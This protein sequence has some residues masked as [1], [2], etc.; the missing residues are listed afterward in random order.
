MS[1]TPVAIIDKELNNIDKIS[2]L[3]EKFSDVDIMRTSSSLDDLEMLLGKKVP[4]LVWIGPTYSLEDIEDQAESHSTTIQSAD[5]VE[6]ATELARVPT[7][8]EMTLAT[9]SKV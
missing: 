2:Y 4:C 6:I 5:I 3:L 1:K 7:I 9:A 8:Y